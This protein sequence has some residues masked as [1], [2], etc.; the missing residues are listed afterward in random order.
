MNVGGNV[1]V[2]DCSVVNEMMGDDTSYGWVKGDK[3][4]I[5]ESVGKTKS[6][7]RMM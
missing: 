1:E 5:R 7:G 6:G 4:E 2:G 3:Y